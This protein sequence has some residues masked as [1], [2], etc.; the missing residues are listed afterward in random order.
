MGRS[1]PIQCHILQLQLEPEE[2]EAQNSVSSPSQPRALAG[3]YQDFCILP[4]LLPGAV[5]SHQELPSG[6]S[7]RHFTQIIHFWLKLGCGFLRSML[8]GHLHLPSL[9]KTVFP[10]NGCKEVTLSRKK[11]RQ[12][13]PS[14]NTPALPAFHSAISLCLCTVCD[15]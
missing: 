8:P 9:S 5:K 7:S 10:W 12:P 1:F 14:G 11:Q 2:T 4:M 6:E 3:L 15:S 13:P